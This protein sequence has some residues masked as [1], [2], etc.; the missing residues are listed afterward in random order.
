MN[1]GVMLIF[2]N[3]GNTEKVREQWN[4][5]I[6]EH[7]EYSNKVGFDS[8]VARGMIFYCDDKLLVKFFRTLMKFKGMNGVSLQGFV[9]TGEL[10]AVFSPLIGSAFNPQ[11]GMFYYQGI[12]IINYRGFKK[13]YKKMKF[14]VDKLIELAS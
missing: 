2:S 10:K 11:Y 1:I 7:K 14:A 13:S 5:F 12:W 6:T 4:K 3:E 9:D 8:N